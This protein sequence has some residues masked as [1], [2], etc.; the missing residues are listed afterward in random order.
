MVDQFTG[1]LYG[2]GAEY[3]RLANELSKVQHQIESTINAGG[4]WSLGTN[5]FNQQSALTRRM[6]DITSGRAA[7][8][9]AMNSAISTAQQGVGVSGAGASAMRGD[10]ASIRNQ[11]RLVNT[12]A[13]KVDAQADALAALVPEYDPYRQRLDGLSDELSALGDMH[14]SQAK[15]IFGQGAALVNLD[16][17]KGGLSA[18]YQKIYD[19]L[20]PERYVSR[21]ASDVQ[22][23][24]AN[25]EAQMNRALARQGVSA[26]SGAMAALRQQLSRQLA[27]ALASGKQNAW[28][29]GVT[30]QGNFL[31]KMTAASKT[32]YD[33]GNEQ[34]SLAQQAKARAGDMQKDAADILSAQG[35]MI[36]DVGALRSQVAGLYAQ[37]ASIFG[38]AA[39]IEGNAANLELSALQSLQTAY[40]NGAN[41]YQGWSRGGS[42]GSV[43]TVGQKGIPGTKTDIHGNI[44]PF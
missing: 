27:T 4:G 17:T 40:Q 3:D 14:T 23:A 25:T 38:S 24:F 31:D 9:T 7:G 29:K 1:G 18:E 5:I 20:S 30:E 41:Y 33:M 21:A 11:A 37:S 12:Q 42:G 22:G 39:G 44:V 35:G 15:D 13:G 6:N 8:D 2:H 43:V 10:A 28:D 16:P 19:L 36:K 32:F 34:S 26:G